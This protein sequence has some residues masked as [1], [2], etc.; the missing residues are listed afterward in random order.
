MKIPTK[1]KTMGVLDENKFV[2]LWDKVMNSENGENIQRLGLD[3]ESGYYSFQS[4]IRDPNWHP[5]RVVQDENGNIVEQVN[6]EDETLKEMISFWGKDMV[7]LI[8]ETKKEVIEY[9]PSGGYGVKMPYNYEKE[10]VVP[11]P[12]I[13]DEILI[14]LLQAKHVFR[15]CTCFGP[16]D[17]ICASGLSY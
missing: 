6:Y 9:N 5:F 10:S 17:E 13:L 8:I 12:Q 1:L 4:E 3:I 15:V 11:Y 14:S 2:E 7:S 16:L